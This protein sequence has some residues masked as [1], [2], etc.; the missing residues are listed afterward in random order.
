MLLPDDFRAA[1]DRQRRKQRAEARIAAQERQMAAE[2]IVLGLR[3]ADGIPAAWLAEHLTDAP[4]A[5]ARYEAAGV[6]A[7][8]DG[9][10]AL[11][12]RGVLISDAIFA[13]LV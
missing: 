11:T 6:L 9:R 7:I 8:R 10:L 1:Q 4:A 2:R 13:E 12:D 5:L 3:L